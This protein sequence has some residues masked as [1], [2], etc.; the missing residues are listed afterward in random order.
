[1]VDTI[2]RD[3]SDIF[4]W[5]LIGLLF[6]NRS[7]LFLVRTFVM[8]LFVSA[9]YFGFSYPSL[10]QNPYTTAVFWSLFWPFFMIVS[11]ALIGPAFCGICPHG[12][13]GRYISRFS[14]NKE[15]PAWLR[16]RGVGLG[17]LLL[18][19]W[20]PVYVFPEFL[21]SPFISSLLFLVLTL[22]AVSSYY[23]FKEMSYCT[24]LCPIGAVTK[25]YGK[26][27]M[28][29]LSTYKEECSK[30]KTFDCAKACKS[31]LQPY[32]FDKKN[33]MRDCTLCMDCAQAC[34]AVSFLVTKPAW[35]LTKNI[36]DKSTV[37]TWV[38]ILLLAVITIT[39]RFHHGL[40][41][42]SIKTSLPWYKIGKWM[43]GFMPAGIDWVGFTAL[44]MALISTFALVLGGFYIGSKIVKTEY[45]VFLHSMSY[46]LIPLMII[47]SLSHVGTFFF[48]SYTSELAKAYYWLIG[49]EHVVRPLATFRDG[50]VHSFGLLSY[51]G[52]VWSQV[53]VYKR[54]GL[55][56]SSLKVKIAATVFSSLI[57]FFDLFLLILQSRVMHH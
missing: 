35:S 26:I 49:S 51:V 11:L 52:A 57:I 2:K 23:L 42:S 47:G 24:Y 25:G 50:W 33:S 15:M 40:G 38:F 4:G 22:I 56:A 21:K 27:G 29:K 17:I 46:A 37:H 41:H 30:C 45:K 18:A 14:L 9:L 10:V 12:V 6:K 16:H 34:E 43:E 54:I 36:S 19:Y 8:V 20:V 28:T 5:T 1:M 48:V 55:F 44:S 39:M 3:K 7:V 32:L 13:M 31:N 53:L